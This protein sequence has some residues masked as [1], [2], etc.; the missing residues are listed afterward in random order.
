MRAAVL[1]LVAALSFA[2][3]PSYAQLENENLLVGM[4]QGFKVGFQDSRNGMNMQEWVPAGETVQNWTEMITA[5]IFLQRADLD[6]VQ[7]LATMAKQWAGACQGSKAT[8]A[9]TG[10][11]TGYASATMLLRCP[12]LASSGKPETTMIK[13]IKGNDS[14]H[15]VQRAVR[16]VPGE[17]QLA[18]TK[19]YLETVSVCDSRLPAHPCLMPGASK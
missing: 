18:R 9:A 14:F 1:C 16:S 6:P 8:P 2:A 12:L 3:A 7:F 15:V 19:A 5:Q 10:K 11:A 13:A 17:A 4:P